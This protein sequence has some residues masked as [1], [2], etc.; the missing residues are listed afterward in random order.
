MQRQEKKSQVNTEVE[1][2]AVINQ[3]MPGMPGRCRGLESLEEPGPA[4]TIISDF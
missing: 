2:Y 1:S 4:H 3:G